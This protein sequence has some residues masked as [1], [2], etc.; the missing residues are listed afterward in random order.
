MKIS[1]LAAAAACDAQTIR[2]YEREG[3]L[4]EPIR[5]NNGY[6]S[7]D[8][9]HLARLQFIRNCRALDIPLAEVRQLLTYAESPRESCANT[10]AL[11]DDH[12]ARVNERIKA[13]QHLKGELAAL[14]ACCDGSKDSLCAIIISFKGKGA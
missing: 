6:R 5:T 9:K 14:R 13:L 1:E 10:N 7:Y 3:L 12:I 11:L 4:S 8:A 2:Y